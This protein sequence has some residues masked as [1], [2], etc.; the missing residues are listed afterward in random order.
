[1]TVP[2]SPTVVRP[3]DSAVEGPAVPLPSKNSKVI[4]LFNSNAPFSTSRP[5]GPAIK[6]ILSQRS[7][8]TNGD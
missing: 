6:L 5:C 4:P 7:L 3:S 8:K 2:R 1:M